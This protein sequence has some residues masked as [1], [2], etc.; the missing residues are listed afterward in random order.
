MVSGLRKNK[1]YLKLSPS[2]D[3]Y[4]MKKTL[5]VIMAIGALSISCASINKPIIEPT[6]LLGIIKAHNNVRGEKG[7]KSVKWSPELATYAQQWANYLA[8]KNNCRMQHR[9][10]S[11]K[12]RQKYGENLYW[13][14]PSMI[15]GSNSQS[16]NTVQK[17]TPTDVVSSWASEEKDYNYATNSCR[18]GKQCGHYTQ[19]VWENST[20]VGCGMAVCADK[21]QLWVCNYNPPG[22]WV[23]EKPY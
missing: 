23:G 7:L 1:K 14:S 17:I 18:P 3:T 10:R 5:A 20:E 22:N 16:G 4:I 19:I 12:Y 8:F 2:R 9:P 11:G 6:K 15:W 13:A 21:G